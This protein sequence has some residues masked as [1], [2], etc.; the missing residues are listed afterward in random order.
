MADAVVATSTSTCTTPIAQYNNKAHMSDDQAADAAKHATLNGHADTSTTTSSSSNASI[1]SGRIPRTPKQ[2]ARRSQLL[3]ELSTIH[4]RDPKAVAA[5]S[6]SSTS[7]FEAS[8]VLSITGNG[9]VQD[10]LDFEDDDDVE[11]DLLQSTY[12]L[13]R[14]PDPFLDLEPE[15]HRPSLSKVCA[16]APMTALI[17]VCM[18]IQEPPL[19]TSQWTQGLGSVLVSRYRNGQSSD[20]TTGMSSIKPATVTNSTYLWLLLLLYVVVVLS[21]SKPS[22]RYSIDHQRRCLE[23]TV[24]G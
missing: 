2:Q 1:A 13:C 12:S 19:E 22:A 5:A 4:Y 7:E 14:I 18:L 11:L 20:S 24:T 15:L 9:I 21:G 8:H 23:E 16:K 17:I 10:N 6:T 3:S